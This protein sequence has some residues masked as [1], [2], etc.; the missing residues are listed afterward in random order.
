MNPFPSAAL[1]S[2][3]TPGGDAPWP[4]FRLPERKDE[5]TAR[6][7]YELVIGGLLLA[8]FSAAGVVG[9]HLLAMVGS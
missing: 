7:I 9:H 2:S 4:H 1:R 6:G 8:L 3:P 5:A